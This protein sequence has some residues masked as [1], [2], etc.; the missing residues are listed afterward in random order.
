M[1]G[2]QGFDYAGSVAALLPD[3]RAVRN[4]GGDL[5]DAARRSLR[6]VRWAKSGNAS[7]GHS[8]VFESAGKVDLAGRLGGGAGHAGYALA[9][10]ASR[11]GLGRRA[12]TY[13][14]ATEVRAESGSLEPAYHLPPAGHAASDFC[15]LAVAYARLSA[16]GGPG[17]SAWNFVARP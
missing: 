15:D 13:R 1:A 8:R 12:R 9:E 16:C 4:D 5:L 10:P 7:S 6:G 2:Q 14:G 17:Q 3:Q 11:P